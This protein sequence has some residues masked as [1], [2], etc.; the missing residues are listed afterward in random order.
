MTKGDEE[1]EAETIIE[2]ENIVPENDIV[3]SESVQEEVGQVV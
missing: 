1:A 3:E 2:S